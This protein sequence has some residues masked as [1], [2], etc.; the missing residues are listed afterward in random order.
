MELGIPNQPGAAAEVEGHRAETVVHRQA[1]AVALDASLVTQG[2]ED[3]FAKGNGGVLDGMVLVNLQIAFRVDGE[4]HHAMFADLLKHVVKE[5]QTGG[6][7]ATA[8]AI[9]VDLDMDVGLL[10][11]TLYLSRAFAGKQQFAD[12]VPRHAF[13]A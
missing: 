13:I 8:S 4:V 7:V 2:R 9:K 10:G 3:A 1:I 12:L 5:T 6:D 11:G